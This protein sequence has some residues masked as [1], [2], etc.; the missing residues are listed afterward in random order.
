[1]LEKQ[2]FELLTEKRVVDKENLELEYDKQGKGITE[3]DQKKKQLEAELEMAMGLRKANEV[4]KDSTDITSKL[5]NEEEK[6]AKDLLD[7]K[8]TVDQ[9]MEEDIDKA[10]TARYLR[11]N[12]RQELV[13][14]KLKLS[15]LQSAKD[16]LTAEGKV[17][18]DSNAKVITENKDLVVKNEKLAKEI[19]LLLQRIDVS[20][21]LKQVD[22]EEMRTLA[23]NNSNMSMSFQGVLFQWD[24]ILKNVEKNLEN[25][26]R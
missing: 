2:I 15:M 25:E 10:D 9:K 12:Q 18:A 6:K 8:I 16:Q 11:K 19:S 4:L 14:K 5:L 23:N 21:L 3:A 22:L 1:M 26:I 24:S 20:T 17:L 13:D 7:Q